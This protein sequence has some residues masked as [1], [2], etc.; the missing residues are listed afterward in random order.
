MSVWVGSGYYHPKLIEIDQVTGSDF[1]LNGTVFTLPT[2][3]RTTSPKKIYVNEDTVGKYWVG[4]YI[5]VLTDA[6][7]I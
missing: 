7:I 4:S 6:I 5:V 2:N 1:R 3:G